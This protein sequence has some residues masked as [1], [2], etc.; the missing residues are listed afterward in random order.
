[1]IL[2]CGILAAL[3]F[4]AI[5]AAREAA[6][7]QM[8]SNDLR[9]IGLALHNY[10]ATFRK[11]PSLHGVNHA[12]EATCSWRVALSPF[13]E[14][15]QVYE[16]FDHHQAWNGP[17]NQALADQMPAYFRSALASPEQP[18]GHTNVFAIRDPRS[19]MPQGGV[20]KRFGEVSDGTSNTLAMIQLPEYSAPWMEP[21]DLTIAEA[22]QHIRASEKPEQ[23]QILLLDGSVRPLGTMSDEDF[24][25]L[26]IIDDGNIVAF[27]E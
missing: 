12:D 20:Y 22:L 21:K 11:L 16:Q 9:M 7:R 5:S 2:G 6:R 10:E 3:L 23:I 8:A 15:V 13:M 18:V 25:S 24:I 17:T 19:I 26:V 4:P 1:M 14:N 27:P